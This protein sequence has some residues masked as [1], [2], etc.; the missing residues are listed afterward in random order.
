[1]IPVE[2]HIV[3]TVPELVGGQLSQSFE[4]DPANPMGCTA[5]VKAGFV[6]VGWFYD[7]ACTNPVPETWITGGTKIVPLVDE[8]QKG[9]DGKEHYFALFEP[10]YTDL[11]IKLSGME[12]HDAAIFQVKGE[13]VDLQVTIVG[14]GSVTIHGIRVA[15]TY[16]ITE[17]TGW[18]W[19]YA[20]VE[21]KTLKTVEGT[22]EVSFTLTA[23]GSDWLNGET[24]T[25]NIFY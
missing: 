20:D 2:Y 8:I 7:E 19:E 3:C 6:F 24:Y 1:M 21:I 9:M 11:T 25:D 15:V 22:N 13:G 10:I 14:N 17:L 23:S 16:E 4:P 18:T 12:E 5:Y